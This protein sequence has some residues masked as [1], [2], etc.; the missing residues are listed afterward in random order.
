MSF[1]TIA[2]RYAQAVYDIGVETDA[3][4]AITEQIRDFADTYAAS[5][6]LRAALSNPLVPD[7]TREAVLQ[8]V[9]QRMGI[10]QVTQNTIRLLARR[11]RLVILPALSQ[12]LQR[13]SDARQG[14]LR[15]HVTSAKPLSEDLSRDLQSKMEQATGKKIIVSQE[16]DESLIAGIVTRIGDTI[17]DGSLRT[18]LLD[19]KSQLLAE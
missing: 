8:E 5:P 4:T 3:L 19:L 1:E 16:V 13:L 17:I 12:S 14:V 6:E 10:S 18:R 15:A 11:R 9:G 7:E 2:K